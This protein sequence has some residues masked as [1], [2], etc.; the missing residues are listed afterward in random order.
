MVNL[1]TAYLHQEY[2]KRHKTSELLKTKDPNSLDR[3]T[4]T[5]SC[6]PYDRNNVDNI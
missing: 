1:V 5:G 2:H 4:V 3:R 6:T